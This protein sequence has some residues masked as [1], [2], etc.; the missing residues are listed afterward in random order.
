MIDDDDDDDD[1]DIFRDLPPHDPNVDRAVTD[2]SLR[3]SVAGDPLRHPLEGLEDRSDAWFLEYVGIYKTRPEYK[4]GFGG[5]LFPASRFY[6]RQFDFPDLGK[7]GWLIVFRIW[8]RD[9]N[10]HHPGLYEVRCG[11]VPPERAQEA[12]HWIAF[13]NQEIRAR[14]RESGQTPKAPDPTQGA[15]PPP[16]PRGTVPVPRLIASVPPSKL[17]PAGLA[18]QRNAAE[19][20][21]RDP[22]PPSPPSPL[23]TATAR[24]R[25]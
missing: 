9:T 12:D 6:K 10:P 18:R 16:A 8:D 1:D 14:L 11:W 13:L 4:H 19:A 17:F 5:Y 25:R 3:P 15:I 22:T 24:R 23:P 20:T 2:E 21:D 7:K